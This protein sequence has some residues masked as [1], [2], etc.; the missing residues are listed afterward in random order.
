IANRKSDPP[1]RY[2]F[3][4][5]LSAIRYP[6]SAIR[7][8]LSAIPLDPIRQRSANLRRRPCRPKLFRH[9]DR[10][11]GLSVAALEDDAVLLPR[12]L[13]VL[14]EHRRL[15]D[16]ARLHLRHARARRGG[17]EE[18]VVAAGEAVRFEEDP[19]AVRRPIRRASLPRIELPRLE[20][21]R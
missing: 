16:R 14:R 7:Y 10:A 8:L 21:R 4:Y 5:P 6:L 9:F 1:I 20:R 18:L 3:R 11:Q 13:G 2:S 17:D 12:P 19:L 15:R